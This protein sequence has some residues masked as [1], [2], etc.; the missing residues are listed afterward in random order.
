LYAWVITPLDVIQ[1]TELGFKAIPYNSN[2]SSG[3]FIKY[4]PSPKIVF[5]FPIFA[6]F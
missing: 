3:T 1:I 4:K 6:P 2:M 5:S